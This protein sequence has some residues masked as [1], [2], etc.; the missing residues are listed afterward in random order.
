MTIISREK[1]ADTGTPSKRDKKSKTEDWWKGMGAEARIAWYR[2]QVR[3]DD[4][5]G[6][7]RD[8]GIVTMEE[9]EKQSS[10]KGRR[11]ANDLVPYEYYEFQ[12]RMLGKKVADIQE[13]WADMV[14]NPDIYRE[15]HE[16]KGQ[17]H[18]FI[19]FMGKIERYRE[20]SEEISSSLK[21]QRDIKGSAQLK[22][23]LAAR[24]SLM[25]AA[26]SANEAAVP[27]ARPLLEVEHNMHD[28]DK[29]SMPALA[30]STLFEQSSASSLQAEVKQDIWQAE[31]TEDQIR[32]EWQGNADEWKHQK[33]AE[34]EKKK[35][36]RGTLLKDSVIAAKAKFDTHLS[37]LE[38]RFSTLDDLLKSL[39]SDAAS[40]G[41]PKYAEKFF[42]DVNESFA[43]ALAAKGAAVEKIAKLKGDLDASDI[44]EARIKLLRES[45]REQV[46]DF[47]HSAAKSLNMNIRDLRKPIDKELKRR[48]KEGGGIGRI[49]SAGSVGFDPKVPVCRL[50]YFSKVKEQL[51]D[52]VGF[53]SGKAAFAVTHTDYA[54][55]RQVALNG[56]YIKNQV[57]YAAKFMVKH[58]LST[59]AVT[60]KA[61][62]WITTFDKRFRAHL[63]SFATKCHVGIGGVEDSW[64]SY[65][66]YSFNK[67]FQYE[68]VGV[69]SLGLPT[70]YY[71]LS[72]KIT[73]AGIKYNKLEGDLVAQLAEVRGFISAEKVGAFD[74]VAELD[75]SIEGRVLLVPPAH[76]LAV[77]SNDATVLQWCFGLMGDTELKTMTEFV[78]WILE[79]DPP[80]VE[81]G[82]DFYGL[83]SFLVAT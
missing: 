13:E 70:A 19:E 50:M 11:M 67:Y 55:F 4:A 62:Q 7:K 54:Q 16:Y 33:S 32:K 29:Q 69:A 71:I 73:L 14:A 53:T 48:E 3:S 59:Q 30:S 24:E 81:P 5:K 72:G 42:A 43:S 8:Y 18:I 57:D 58:S 31:Q 63:P 49:S 27:L 36:R 77:V 76:I 15:E 47:T 83:S 34:A 82:H 45:A 6:T 61:K 26:A 65:F 80:V 60:C 21:R 66:K 23:A 38:E 52:E 39:K 1:A 75:A 17:K 41:D 40:L 37:H 74:W 22:I 28:I 79:Q 78:Q 44:D 51:G 12:M 64:S 20:D 68:S 56:T 10:K 2:R 25:S 9:E 35:S 46:D